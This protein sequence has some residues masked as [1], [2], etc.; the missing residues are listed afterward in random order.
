MTRRIPLL[1]AMSL[2]VFAPLQ[3]Q[4]SCCCGDLVV[5]IELDGASDGYAVRRTGAKAHDLPDGRDA[6]GVVPADAENGA[7][8]LLL[9]KERVG[10][11]FV[12]TVAWEITEVRTGRMMQLTFPRPIADDLD[13]EMSTV[14]FTPGRY[15]YHESGF[16]FPDPGPLERGTTPGRQPGSDAI[17]R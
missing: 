14:R 15:T 8:H 11:G 2:W 16:P 12:D 6:N 7:V 17:S 3:A 9:L 5:R 4:R 10:C 13:L 1:L